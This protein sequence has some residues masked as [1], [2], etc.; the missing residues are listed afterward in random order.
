MCVAIPSRL[1]Q[2]LTPTNPS[3]AAN[4]SKCQTD[5]RI[6]ARPFV[7]DPRFRPSEERVSRASPLGALH[8]ISVRLSFR[9][10][11]SASVN[12]R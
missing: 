8:R 10:I 3:L 2:C 12:E 11:L 1:G 5:S 4:H 6:R 9:F 7:P